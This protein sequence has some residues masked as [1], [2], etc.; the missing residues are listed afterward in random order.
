MPKVKKITTKLSIVPSFVSDEAKTKYENLSGK[1]LFLEKGFDVKL[2]QRWRCS[3]TLRMHYCNAARNSLGSIQMIHTWRWCSSLYANF[4]DKKQDIVVV[5]AKEVDITATASN[6]FYRLQDFNLQ[7]WIH[8]LHLNNT[9][10]QLD[11]VLRVI[12]IEG[13][14]GQISS[15]RSRTCRMIAL[16]QRAKVWYHFL[17]S[18]LMPTMHDQ[19]VSQDRCVL[20]YC[21]LTG[22]SI[23]V[24][25][26]I[27]E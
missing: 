24:G 14:Q 8:S 20:L 19:T 23:N 15:T 7:R 2:D 16:T 9:N 18:R 6:D 27:K 21:I 25:K 4:L 5:R 12:C 13:R 1:G 11:E 26:C 3:L 22:K 10:E 17:R